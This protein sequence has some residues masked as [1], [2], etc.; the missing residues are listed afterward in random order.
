MA[1][2]LKPEKKKGGMYRRCSVVVNG[3]NRKVNLGYIALKQANSVFAVIEELEAIKRVDGSIAPDLSSKL[4]RL[5]PKILAQLVRV[6]LIRKRDNAKTLGILF[7]AHCDMKRKTADARSVRNYRSTLRQIECYFGTDREI[8][9]ITQG[10]VREFIADQ[11]AAKKESGTI[12]NYLTRGASAFKYAV[13]KKWTIENPFQ[14]LPER[15]RFKRKL[16]GYK[17]QLQKELLTH[18]IVNKLLD[19]KKSERSDQEDREWNAL[20]W[21]LRWTGCRIAEACILRW[22]DID[23]NSLEIKLRGKRKGTEGTS[24]EDME[25]RMMPLWSPLVRVLSE[26]RQSSA[27][28]S[29]HVFNC[30]GQLSAKPEFDVTDNEGKVVKAGRWSANLQTTFKKILERNG[31]TPWPQPFHAIRRYRINEMERDSNLRTVD[32]REWTGHCEAT[33]QGH[34]S[35]TGKE[36]RQKAARAAGNASGATVEDESTQIASDHT[37][38]D[39]KAREIRE[40]VQ[41]GLIRDHLKMAKVHPEGVPDWEELQAF[42]VSLLTQW[43]MGGATRSELVEIFVQ[44]MRQIDFD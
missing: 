37:S 43:S 38:Q 40:M 17:K 12:G 30:I 21:F 15:K 39:E 36:D 6:G 3:E 42:L 1:T 35:E 11:V 10:C 13:Q 2:M 26:L 16:A 7:D 29:P 44:A 32:I 27:D 5:C 28:E 9:S 23:F 34:Y 18:A 19:C 14:G 33:A 31:L 8:G 4:D 20:T 41:S 22:E 25:V 24:S